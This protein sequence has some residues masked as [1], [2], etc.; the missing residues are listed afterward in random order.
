MNPQS[1]GGEFM[2]MEGDLR[3]PV[4]LMYRA[5][6]RDT[7]NIEANLGRQHQVVA[8]SSQRVLSQ[9]DTGSL[10]VTYSPYGP[11]MQL[12]IIRQL[13][14]RVRAELNWVL[15]PAEE[16]GVV[17][18]VTRS[19]DVWSVTGKL[20]VQMRLS[21]LSPHLI[22]MLRGSSA[23][24]RACM[25]NNEHRDRPFCID[26][27]LFHV[28]AHRKSADAPPCCYVVLLHCSQCTRNAWQR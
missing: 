5:S 7:F 22:E 24:M 25:V 20:Q 18:N 21:P 19:S 8:V 4:S 14:D 13:Y 9:R 28:H 23:C 11:G 17:F 27:F 3:V 15:G 2:T 16:A 1:R 26:A 12:G 10:T 6:Q